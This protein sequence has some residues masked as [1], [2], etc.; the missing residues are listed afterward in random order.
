MLGMVDKGHLGPGVDADITIY[1]PDNN[2]EVMF[3][4]PRYVLKSGE[5]LVDDGEPRPCGFG[6]THHV[7]PD[8]DRAVVPS[9]RAWFERESSISFA[10]FPVD[11]AVV[12]ESPS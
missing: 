3:S 7:E 5:I 1:R 4:M 10:N 2:R 9:V 12:E 11:E 8:F 6:T